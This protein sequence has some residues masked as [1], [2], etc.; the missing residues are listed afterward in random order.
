MT[1]RVIEGGLT[2]GRSLGLLILGASEIATLAGGL[3]SGPSQDQPACA[4]VSMNILDFSVTPL[5]LVWD[6]VRTEA[7]GDGLELRESELIGLCPLAAFLAVAD[8]AGFDPS[9]SVEDRCAA[10]AGYLHLRDFSP[11]QVLELRLAAAQ[12]GEG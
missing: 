3:R 11:M 12:R 8:H 4:Q 6:T 9:A 5:W 2:D 1:L 7:A 10:A